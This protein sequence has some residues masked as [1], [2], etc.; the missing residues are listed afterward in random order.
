LRLVT[1]LP[2]GSSRSLIS[3]P[4]VATALRAVAGDGKQFR[5]A[6]DLVAWLGLTLDGAQADAARDQRQRL[7]SPPHH[8]GCSIVPDAPRSLAR[9]ATTSPIRK[10]IRPANTIVDRARAYSV[11]S[12]RSALRAQTIVPAN[13]VP[14]WTPTLPWQR[15]SGGGPWRAVAAAN[16]I[17]GWTGA[18]F[19]YR[20]SLVCDRSGCHES[21]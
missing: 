12:M 20:Q 15:R 8:L 10:A 4:L 19:R 18:D 2:D 17:A 13:V 11:D 16:E 9:N 3:G 14:A 5:K 7:R 6:R 1:T 21:G